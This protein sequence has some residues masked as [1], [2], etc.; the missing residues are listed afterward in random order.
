MTSQ[1]DSETHARARDSFVGGD[2][3][4]DNKVGSLTN[5]GANTNAILNSKMERMQLY[6]STIAMKKHQFKAR[7]RQKTRGGHGEGIIDSGNWVKGVD[8]T[9][10]QHWINVISLNHHWVIGWLNFVWFDSM[11]RWVNWFKMVTR[12]IIMVWWWVKVD[13]QNVIWY[14]VLTMKM[15]IFGQWW[16]NIDPNLGCLWW[17][18][19]TIDSIWPSDDPIVG[20]PRKATECGVATSEFNIRHGSNH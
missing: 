8:S 19:L 15:D 12:W 6:L 10:I 2:L 14:R 20:S 3:A 4:G 16:L 5:F 1:P 18:E 13:H 17:F 9:L 11:N 7:T